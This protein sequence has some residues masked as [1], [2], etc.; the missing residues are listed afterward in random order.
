M[1]INIHNFNECSVIWGRDQSLLRSNYIIQ[2]ALL[3]TNKVNQWISSIPRNQDDVPS[4][5][6][7][8]QTERFPLIKS[9]IQVM[10]VVAFYRWDSE[11]VSTMQYKPF[12]FKVKWFTKLS[13]NIHWN[14]SLIKPSNY[15]TCV[16]SCKGQLNQFNRTGNC[17]SLWSVI[18]K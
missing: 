6:T 3:N 13:T 16:P 17:C 15:Y 2:K 14:R 11:Y 9:Y 4:D 1:T 18:L 10:S 7:E 5:N 8:A 12:R